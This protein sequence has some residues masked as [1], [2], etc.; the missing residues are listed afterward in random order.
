MSTTTLHAPMAPT[1]QDQELLDHQAQ[2]RRLVW[3]RRILPAIGVATTTRS[4]SAR[5]ST[6]VADSGQGMAVRAAGR[7]APGR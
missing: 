5:R 6:N 1:P 7:A 4:E 2:R 3:R